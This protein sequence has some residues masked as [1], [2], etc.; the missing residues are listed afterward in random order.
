MPNQ[1]LVA[2]F[3]D[4]ETLLRAVR[5]VRA[6]NLPIYD[7]YAPYPVHNLDEAMGIRRTRLPLVTLVVAAC[8]MT[9][10]FCFQFYAAVLDWPLNVGGKPDNSS[11]AFLPITFEL[12]VLSS[13]LATVAAL[14]VR[15]RLFPGKKER[16]PVPGI[17]NDR[18]ALVLRER[19]GNFDVGF[20]SRLMESS[21][22]D[23]VWEIEGKL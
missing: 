18:F 15:A 12:T 8:A 23:D 13:G 10:A 17:T 7:V 3:R 5:G 19:S 6:K 9:F 11:L 16:L 14:L 21:G 20:A 4:P 1:Y 22:A 2:S